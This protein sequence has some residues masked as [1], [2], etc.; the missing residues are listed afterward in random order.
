[1]LLDAYKQDADAQI[2][3]QSE[4][5]ILLKDQV[6][7]ERRKGWLIPALSLLGGFALGF[8]VTR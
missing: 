8:I 4:E 3:S 2:K 1:M 6:E 5:V 7:S